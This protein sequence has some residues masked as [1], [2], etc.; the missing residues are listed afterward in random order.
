M[1]YSVATSHW[2]VCSRLFELN[3]QVMLPTLSC[4]ASELSPCCSKKSHMNLNH[5]LFN[6]F[7]RGFYTWVSHF[8]LLNSFSR[9][10]FNNRLH[11][12]NHLHATFII[13]F[14]CCLSSPPFLWNSYFVGTTGTNMKAVYEPLCPVRFKRN[15]GW[16]MDGVPENRQSLAVQRICCDQRAPLFASRR[17]Y[18][19]QRHV[20]PLI[21]GED[22]FFNGSHSTQSYS[23]CTLSFV[24]GKRGEGGL[25]LKFVSTETILF[26][27]VARWTCLQ[28]KKSLVR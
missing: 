27:L 13:S 17:S 8:C 16:G 28:N 10:C 3:S 7:N 14:V 1:H 4:L 24:L 25:N 2:A 20:T 21:Y 22:F 19:S 6:F 18:S 5:N 15:K 23:G 26:H 9:C 11:R 12:G